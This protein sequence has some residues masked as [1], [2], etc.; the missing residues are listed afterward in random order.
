LLF[1]ARFRNPYT[2]QT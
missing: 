1:I 2:K